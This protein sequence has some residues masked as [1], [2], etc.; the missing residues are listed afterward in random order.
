[1]PNE[2]IYEIKNLI[3]GESVNVPEKI[4]IAVPN[5]F[6][7]KDTIVKYGDKFMLIRWDDEPI[8]FR[9]F[10]D[11]FGRDKNYTLIYYEWK[12]ITSD[13]KDMIEYYQSQGLPVPRTN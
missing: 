3:K 10:E 11:K 13:E 4:L 6:Y 1:M 12:P 7:K 5:S 9:T 2:K 8:T